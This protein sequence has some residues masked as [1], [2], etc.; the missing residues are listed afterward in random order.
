MKQQKYFD[1]AYD[2]LISKLYNNNLKSN[3]HVLFYLKCD[4]PGPK[5]QT[6]WNFTYPPF[7]E[8][9][10][11]NE[12][13]KF[14]NKYK[15]I[16]FH[17]KI[18]KTNEISDKELLSQVKCREKYQKF[19]SCDKKL[20]RGLHCHY[21]I[22]RCNEIIEEIE[23]KHNLK[24][25]HFIYVRPDLYFLTNCSHISQFNLNKIITGYFRPTWKTYH[26]AIIP[27]KYKYE[28]FLL[29]WI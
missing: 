26:I 15:N 5:G 18:L 22:Y 11:K 20:L 19:F 12:I 29:G 14:M 2:K 10:L 6:G 27:R 17:S 21:N 9:M 24:F 8:E 13:S 7:D 4:D 28:F 16:T 25:D 23:R 3:T 1:S